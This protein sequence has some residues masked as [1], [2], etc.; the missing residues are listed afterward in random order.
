ML[1]RILNDMEKECKFVNINDF[2]RYKQFI[3]TRKNHDV[4]TY[5]EKHHIYP[6]SLCNKEYKNDYINLI[7]LTAREH[8]I[9]H[10]ILWKALGGKMT[11]AFLRIVNCKKYNEK[12]TSRQYCKLRED[13]AKYSSEMNKGRK[14]PKSAIIITADKNRGKKRTEELKQRMSDVNKGQTH[15]KEQDEK[16]SDFLKGRIWVKKGTKSK[17][18]LKGEL[19]QYLADGYVKGRY[20]VYTKE[21]LEKISKASKNRKVSQKTKDLYT[22]QRKGMIGIHKG[23]IKK[24]VKKDQLEYFLK[25]GYVLGWKI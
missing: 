24:R 2:Y 11:N 23:N 9:A 4:K 12:I 13:F 21:A 19:N 22:E 16:H 5:T 25:D 18:I 14:R 1:E 20:L 17:Q 7:R 8:Y 15:S 3:K 6:R 10:M